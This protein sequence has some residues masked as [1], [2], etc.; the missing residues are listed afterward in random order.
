MVLTLPYSIESGIFGKDNFMNLQATLQA[1]SEKTGAQ[2][3]RYN[4]EVAIVIVSVSGGRNQSVIGK[5]VESSLYN[6]KTIRITS[7]IGAYSD[8]MDLKH[9]LEQTAHFNYCRF[10]IREGQ[11]EVEAVAEVEGTSA[12]TIFEMITETANLADQ[13]EMTLTKKDRN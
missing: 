1:F 13:F 2:F 7:V 9:L 3:I 5:I 10:V 12:E 4:D 11:L 8:G 6:R